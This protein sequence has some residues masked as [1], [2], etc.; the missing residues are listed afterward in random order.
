MTAEVVIDPRFCGPPDSANGG[1]AC[2][3]LGRLLR[4]AVEVTL[5][6]PP[7]VGKPLSVEIRGSGHALLLDG[8]VIVAEAIPSQL[9]LEPPE[10]VAVEDAVCASARYAG[11]DGHPF[12]TC[13]VCGPQRAEGD[14]LR[15]FAGPLEERELVA[16]PWTPARDL[17]SER[18]LVHPEFVWA[19]L[20]CPGGFACG[21]G[22]DQELLLGRLTAELY[23]PVPAG[24]LHVAVGW[25]LG[26]DGRKLHAGTA[27]FSAAG[28]LKAAAR[29]T[30]ITP[31]A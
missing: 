23:A 8:Q 22:T 16:S 13:F 5:R 2:G 12:P 30:W 18:A 24:E 3:L 20:D 15:I 26:A 31:R 25:P 11:F 28:E 1:Y 9:E 17:A 21:F 10:P 7:P 6:R 19:S 14:G 4:G 29:A 27:L